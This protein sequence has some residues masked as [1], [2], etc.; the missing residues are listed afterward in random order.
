MLQVKDDN[1]AVTPATKTH[2]KVSFDDG[3]FSFMSLGQLLATRQWSANE[4][5]KIDLVY[6]SIIRRMSTDLNG[7]PCDIER[8]P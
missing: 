3:S 2:F 5:S 1:G 6:H 7:T 8:R 4:R